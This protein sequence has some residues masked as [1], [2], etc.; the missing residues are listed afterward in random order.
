MSKYK[1]K[2]PG[3]EGESSTYSSDESVWEATMSDAPVFG[4]FSISSSNES[5]P[6]DE[7]RERA[8]VTPLSSLSPEERRSR[9]VHSKNPNFDKL[10]VRVAKDREDIN[11]LQDEDERPRRRLNAA[12]A[13]G[14]VSRIGTSISEAQAE[15]AADSDAE[16]VEP[17]SE[18]EPVNETQRELMQAKVEAMKKEMEA[19]E[20]ALGDEGK[21]PEQLKEKRKQKYGKAALKIF[22]KTAEI[23]GGAAAGAAIPMIINAIAGAF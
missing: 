21:S 15:A 16:D 1:L 6:S 13:H 4:A 20:K 18:S 19:I 10:V 11:E 9:I 17:Q 7:P 12:D 5:A 3:G 22:A 2:E 14:D 8:I 23:V